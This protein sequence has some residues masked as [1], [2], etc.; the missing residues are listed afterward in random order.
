MHGWHDACLDDVVLPRYVWHT[1]D[2]NVPLLPQL[3][4]YYGMLPAIAEM[5]VQGGAR[6]P[7]EFEKMMRTDV[8]LPDIK[9][10]KMVV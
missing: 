6:A 7:H 10:L 9:E 8:V 5:S 3:H 2:P 4:D 1:P